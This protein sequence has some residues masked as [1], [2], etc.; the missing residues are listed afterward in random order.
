MY[1]IG[2][3]Q[4]KKV[5]K[6]HKKQ[7]NKMS[8]IA[9][10]PIKETTGSIL[11]MQCQVLNTRWSMHIMLTDSTSTAYMVD[12]WRVRQ[13]CS[14]CTSTNVICFWIGL[15]EVGKVRYRCKVVMTNTLTNI[16]CLYS[17]LKHLQSNQANPPIS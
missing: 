7:E 9:V 14:K 11:R 17:T 12:A 15:T 6:G 16:D 8:N 10:F 4:R 2:Q 1:N 3:G 5:E 13:K